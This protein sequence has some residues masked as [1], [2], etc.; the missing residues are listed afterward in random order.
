VGPIDIRYH[1]ISLAAVFLALGVGI[2]VGSSTNFFGITSILDRQNRVIERLEANYKD[3]R[4]EVHDTRVELN[5][6]KQYVS[7]LEGE[8]IPKL[9]SGKLDG[10]R[11]GVVTVGDLP[12]ENAS[13]DNLISPL[14][15]AGAANA[16][17]LRVSPEKLKELADDDTGAFVA[18]FGK[19][20]LRGAA[21]GAR[22]TD[23]FMKDGS[24]VSG[25]FE[26]PVDGIIFI[27]GEN[28]DLKVIREILLP[29]EKL[30]QGNQG[31][32]LN[33]VYGVQNS[34]EQI[35]KPANL[36]YFSNSEKISGQIEIISHLQEVYKQK[37]GLKK[38]GT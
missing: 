19:E 17:K 20:I 25:S 22:Y 34:Y 4:K 26:K 21:F 13:E 31:V 5:A 10:F 8:M 16:Y 37:Q 38:I 11:Y 36:L 24:V 14:K 29:L 12:G 27:I 9:L 23:P 3:I 15:S 28:V 6:S 32:P 30:V 7:S 35:F 1:A 33:A 18:Q 2:I